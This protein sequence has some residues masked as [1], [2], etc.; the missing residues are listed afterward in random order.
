MK[1]SMKIDGEDT[2]VSLDLKVNP[3]FQYLVGVAIVG[4]FGFLVTTM[5]S[6]NSKL[7]T[8][9]SEITLVKYQITLLEQKQ[10]TFVTNEQVA[11]LG[12]IRDMQLQ[13]YETRLSAV[14][15]R[16]NAI[17]SQIRTF[18]TVTPAHGVKR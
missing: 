1:T 8:V 7:N 3:L 5:V 13:G 4:F 6:A 9:V 14:D 10:N 18:P 17:E 15:Q 16:L 12:K 11:Q 2:G